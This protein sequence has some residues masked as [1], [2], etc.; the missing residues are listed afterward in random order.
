MSIKNRFATCA[1]AAVVASLGFAA[2]AQ[3]HPYS[4][5]VV[6]NVAQIRTVDG[7]F[8]DYMKWLATEWKKQQEIAKKLGYIVGY[9]V[10]TVEPRAPDDADILLVTRYRNWAALDGALAKGDEVV[11]QLGQ[12]NDQA[13]KEQ[14]ARASI[15]TVL[16]SSTMQVLDLK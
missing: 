3:D 11:K 9:E 10:I 8:D 12:T 2:L 13:S 1:A 16:G 14:V 4:E 6:I 7:H 5:G 15:R